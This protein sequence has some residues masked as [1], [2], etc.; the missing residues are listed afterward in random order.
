MALA[1]AQ[2]AMSALSAYD[3]YKTAK[4]Q[5]RYQQQ[6]ADQNAE[7]AELRAADALKRGDREAAKIKTKT[8]GLLGRQRAILAAQGFDLSSGTALDLQEDTVGMGAMDEL[9]TKNNAWR[10]AFGFK[11]EARAY[12][13]QGRFA[14]LEA[15]NTARTSLLTGGLRAVEAGVAGYDRF[16][17]SKGTK[18]KWI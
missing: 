2:V 14:K 9:T 8:S 17:S 7:M 12:R 10:E 18:R 3:Q 1:S 6:I 13:T 11:S 4:A 5:G 15:R 16:Q